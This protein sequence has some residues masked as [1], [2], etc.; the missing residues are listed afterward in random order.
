MNEA[1]LNYGS[2]SVTFKKSPT[3]IG[4]KPIPRRTDEIRILARRMGMI[5]SGNLLGQFRVATVQDGEMEATLDNV[6]SDPSVVSGTH[7]FHTSDDNVPFVPTGQLYLV[8]QDTCKL[9]ECQKMIERHALEVIRVLGERE[10]IVRVTGDSPNPIKVA[11]Y[12]QE[13]PSL[14]KVAE[15]ELATPGKLASFTLPSDNLLELQWHLRNTGGNGGSVLGLKAGADA[16]VV[17]AWRRASTFGSPEVIVGVIDDGFDLDHPDLSGPGKIVAP[18]DFT[19]GSSNPRPDFNSDY[20]YFDSRSGEWVGDWHG[21]ACAGV[22][23]GNAN[24]Q[25]ILGG[26]PASRLMPVRW[27]IDLSDQQ[28]VSWFDYVR[29][30]GAAVVSCSWGAAARVFPLSSRIQKAIRDCATQ[31]RNGKGSVICFAAGNENSDI[32]DPSGRSLN[33]F[34]IHPNVIAVA[35]CNSRDERSH[36]S[37]FGDAISVCAP[38]NGRG[39]RGVVTADVQGTFNRNGQAIESGYSPGAFTDGF[40]GTSSATPLVA[41]VCALLLSVNPT[42]TAS[43]IKSLIQET[44]RK[45][46]PA[47]GYQNGHSRNFGYGCIDAAAAVSRLLSG[48]PAGP[49]P[50]QKKS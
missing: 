46:G 31:G 48:R 28:V 50:K 30:Q 20:P 15:P 44:A 3:L 25:G 4:V 9:S 18:W 27:G 1:T 7:V 14:V 23:V 43:Q 21:T 24:G 17:E 19:R 32:N 33:G 47:S 45:I 38:S 10:L 37:N 42:L 35:A 5:E 16:R 22:A 29:R 13:K 49:S 34:A 12:F 26:A 8:F 36:Y 39:G 11:A 41:G 40:G 6:R 2:A